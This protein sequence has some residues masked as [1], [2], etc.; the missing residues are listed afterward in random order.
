MCGNS[1][2]AS[3][4]LFVYI[5][6]KKELGINYVPFGADTGAFCIR[7]NCPVEFFDP[8]GLNRFLSPV[9]SVLRATDCD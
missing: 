6:S 3:E 5:V 8:T 1:I 9:V 2:Y 4:A 7:A